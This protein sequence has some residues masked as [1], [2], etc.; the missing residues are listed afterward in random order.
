M[1]QKTDLIAEIHDINSDEILSTCPACDQYLAILR[2]SFLE[3]GEPEIVGGHWREGAPALYLV[4]ECACG[5]SW[6]VIRRWE[7]QTA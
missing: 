5:A 2:L 1:T 6:A 7:G 4:F 3:P